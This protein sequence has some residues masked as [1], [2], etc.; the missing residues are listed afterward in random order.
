MSTAIRRLLRHVGR[1][2]AVRRI[3]KKPAKSGF[4]L[5]KLFQKLKVLNTLRARENNEP[6]RPE[7]RGIL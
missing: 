5:A 4:P 2:H 3:L 1:S 6:P 7:G